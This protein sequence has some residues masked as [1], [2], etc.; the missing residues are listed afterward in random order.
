MTTSFDAVVDVTVDGEALF[1]AVPVAEGVAFWVASTLETVD[2]VA[3]FAF[4]A[5]FE[6]FGEEFTTGEVGNSGAVVF[7]L[8][9]GTG[10]LRS[11]GIVAI[12]A[13]ILSLA[14]G[15]GWMSCVSRAVQ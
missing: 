8:D 1:A 2:G 9:G 14:G 15:P 13:S 3:N 5:L 10:A 11:L 4:D 6:G 7:P 12:V